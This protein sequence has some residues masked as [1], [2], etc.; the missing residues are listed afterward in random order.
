MNEEKQ[1]KKPG[2]KPKK[3]E[4]L[5]A[6]PAP[7]STNNIVETKR[8][9]PEIVRKLWLELAENAQAANIP[10]YGCLVQITE[11]KDGQLSTSLTSIPGV[12]V[13]PSK[14]GGHR[15]CGHLQKDEPEE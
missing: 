12:G 2:P 9:E 6:Q 13:Y 14:Y 15:L 3:R 7:I 10:G 8:E 4:T 5:I 11:A 1:R